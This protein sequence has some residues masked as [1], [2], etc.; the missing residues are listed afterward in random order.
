MT[1]KVVNANIRFQS[2]MV[3]DDIVRQLEM[4]ENEGKNIKKHRVQFNTKVK[5]KV[6]PNRQTICS[7][8]GDLWWDS[9]T[10]RFNRY[11]FSNEIS[12]FMFKYNYTNF[13]ECSTMFWEDY[14]QLSMI[15]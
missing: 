1:N 5:Y 8:K 6:I 10:Y 4:Q 13:K 2:W 11:I 14:L 3:L 7:Y 15:L 9:T 12:L